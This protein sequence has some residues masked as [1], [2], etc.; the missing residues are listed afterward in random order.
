MFQFLCSPARIGLAFGSLIWKN[1]A[2]TSAFCTAVSIELENRNFLMQMCRVCSLRKK[3]AFKI[4]G[5][6][7]YRAVEDLNE[8][9]ICVS[10]RVQ[11]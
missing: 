4:E 6:P 7:F 2:N 10:S 3:Y 8:D 1:P 9:V 5:D 11:G